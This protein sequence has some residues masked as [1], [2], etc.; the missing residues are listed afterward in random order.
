MALGFDVQV[1]ARGTVHEQGVKDKDF[2]RYSPR[3]CANDFKF[4]GIGMG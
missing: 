1:R 4:A 3:M 2:F